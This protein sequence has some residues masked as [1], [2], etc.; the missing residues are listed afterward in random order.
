MGS[1]PKQQKQTTQ[2]SGQQQQA[3]TT[4][5]TSNLEQFGRTTQ[6]AINQ[7]TGQ[8]TLELSPEQRALIDPVIPIAQQYLAKP[9]TLMEGSQVAG[10]DPWQTMAQ[11]QMVG[12][13]GQQGEGLERALGQ[14]DFFTSGA[15]LDPEQNPGLQGTIDAATRGIFRNLGENTLPALRDQEITHGQFGG[16]RGEIAEGIAARGAAEQAGD[17]T[18]QLLNQNYLTGLGQMNQA[19]ALTPQM[20]AQLG[21]PARMVGEAGAQRQGLEQRQLDE[22]AFRHSFEQMSPWMAAQEVANLGISLPG[23][24]TTTTGTSTQQGTTESMVNSLAE[25]IAEME[26]TATSSGMGTTTQPAPVRN[27]ATTALGIGSLLL[28]MIPG[29]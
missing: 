3:G 5:T 12:A 20:L 1:K 10:F 24:T 17:V 23:G 16:S 8:A 15:V 9:P 2:Q 19:L 22:Q 21:D 26:G 13:A 7:Q 6:D 27:K 29:L 14:A 4:E 25:A 18:S 28:G 11:E